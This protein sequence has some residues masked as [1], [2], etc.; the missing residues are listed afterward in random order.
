MKIIESLLVIALIAGSGAAQTPDVDPATGLP[1]KETEKVFDLSFPGG[2]P[3]QFV[4]AVE[5]AAKISLNVIIP[6]E[7][8]AVAL[9]PLKVKNVTVPQLFQALTMASTKQE[10]RITGTYFAMAGKPS[11]QPQYQIVTTKF[12]FKTTD[13]RPRGNSIWYFYHDSPPP[14]PQGSPATMPQQCRFWQLDP[15]LETY[16][17]E[18]ITTAIETGWHMAKVTPG[19]QMKFHKETK[20]LVV[21][22]GADGLS[23][24]DDVLREL[25][26]RVDP[27]P[28]PNASISPANKS[29]KE[30]GQV[31]GEKPSKR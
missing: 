6:H 4:D 26:P 1:L 17:V 11:P 27:P 20:L 15:Y 10:T 5:K 2:P 19:P 7:H 23:I 22:G 29:A 9:P 14:A 18:D 28:N 16:K 31:S 12:G 25:G 24:V 3:R 30:S 21:V 8:E 13:E